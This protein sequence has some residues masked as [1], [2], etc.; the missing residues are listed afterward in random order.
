MLFVRRGAFWATAALIALPAA[1]CGRAHPAHEAPGLDASAGDDADD[2]SPDGGDD[3][4]DDGP[5]L[6]AP[7]DAAPVCRTC[8]SSGWTCGK[9]SDGCGN[10]IDCGTCKAPQTCGGGG[11]S[12][13]GLAGGDG[14]PC[15]PT[16]CKG[17]GYNCGPAGDGCGG[18]LQCGQCAPQ[19]VCG[20][21]GPGVCGMPCGGLCSQQPVCEGG[22]STIVSG[23]VVAG[24]LPAY[25]SPDP[26]PN[27]LV[28]V[29]NGPLVPFAPGV[30]CSQCGAEVTG[31]P[32]VTTHT[33][34]D[35]TFSLPNVPAGDAI[36]IVIQLGRWRRLV[37][38][39]VP[40]CATTA[41][42]DIHMPRS[43]GEGDIPR[44][45]I[46]T[47]SADAMECVLL[48]MGVDAAE[49]TP[50]T[51][52]GR[53]HVFSGYDADGGFNGSGAGAGPGTRPESALTGDHGQTLF[54]YDQ[55]LF[56]CWGD[57]Y[58]KGA[59]DL[60]NLVFYADQGGRVFATHYSYSWLFQN[61]P[62]DQT[63]QWNPNHGA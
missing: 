35:G 11:Y 27:V 19:L 62:F 5:T 63:A 55:V 2:T 22:G 28:Y 47:G 31:N 14:G 15:V 42:G 29:P 56:P 12:K 7:A 13:C 44:T 6:I 40:A 3:T 52:A 24:T 39:K 23:R 48:K 18:L 30:Q 1:A 36:P 57:Q 53:I 32:L 8:K 10:I 41:L 37:T 54:L 34:Y 38:F 46:S 45:A 9:N 33:A 20:A 60:A 59:D 50:D 49:F 21:A 4:G 16:T 43:Q 61:P 58:L 25:G 26:V 51:G 17:L